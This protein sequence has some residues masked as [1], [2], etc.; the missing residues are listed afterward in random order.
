M[1][2]SLTANYAL[3]APRFPLRMSPLAENT[4]SASTEEAL[5]VNTISAGAQF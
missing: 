3:S 1:N 2:D 4:H 5:R